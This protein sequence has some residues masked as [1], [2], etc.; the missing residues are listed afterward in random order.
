MNPFEAIVA[1]ESAAKTASV[2]P[3]DAI[4]ADEAAA[5]A[6][7]AQ[8][9]A[10]VDEF[11]EIK[12]PQTRPQF[13]IM[14]T[15]DIELERIDNPE[16][17]FLKGV[18]NAAI[19]AIDFMGDI[20]PDPVGAISKA[21][22]DT[23]SG[24]ATLPTDIAGRDDLSEK[25]NSFIPEII[26]EGSNAG[27]TN[28][29]ADVTRYGG[30][31]LGGGATVARQIGN[32]IKDPGTL[33]KI[34]KYATSL[35]GFG[36][37]DAAVMNPEKDLLIGDLLKSFNIDTGTAQD[38]DKSRAD[39]RVDAFQ[40][41][42]VAAPVVDAAMVPLKVAGTLAGKAYDGVKGYRSLSDANIE[43][44]I[45]EEI[46]SGVRASGADPAKVADDMD[47]TVAS[48]SDDAQLTSGQ[49]SNN[50]N[51]LQLDRGM[52][53]ANN[54]RGS[55]GVAVRPSTEMSARRQSQEQAVDKELAEVTNQKITREQRDVGEDAARAGIRKAQED[56]LAPLQQ[57]VDDASA[58]VASVEAKQ[59]VEIE[60][61]AQTAKN[62]PSASQSLGDT[63]EDAKGS[64]DSQ[65]NEAFDVDPEGIIKRK[66]QGIYDAWNGTKN[67]EGT[68]TAK[69]A[70][71][72]DSVE[73]IRSQLGKKTVEM[74]DGLQRGGD[75]VFNNIQSIRNG[76]TKAIKAATD[77][78]DGV[79][80]RKLGKLKENLNAEFERLA[81]QGGGNPIV[82]KVA[83]KASDAVEFFQS[84]YAPLLRDGAGK[85]L[86]D[87]IAK[88]ARNG[89]EVKAFFKTDAAGKAAADEATRLKGL[90][91]QSSDPAKGIKEVTDFVMA[92][93][94]HTTKQLN[95]KSIDNYIN[96]HS[97]LL[98]EFPEAKTVLEKL[99][100]NVNATA[101]DLVRAKKSFDD[102]SGALKLSEKE[103]NSSRAAQF[104]NDDPAE[105]AA[106]ALR[107]GNPEKDIVDMLDKA[108]R[109]GVPGAKEGVEQ[110]VSDAIYSMVTNTG[111]KSGDDLID[112]RASLGKVSKLLGK[113]KVRK[114]LRRVH[115]DEG[116]AT[117]DK[118]NKKLDLHA[119]QTS[120]AASDTAANVNAAQTVN[121][122]NVRIMLAAY[123]GITKGR[124]IHTISKYISDFIRG[125]TDARIAR[126]LLDVTLNP[127]KGA[128]FLRATTQKP[129]SAIGKRLEAND[130]IDARKKKFEAHIT[131]NYPEFFKDE[132]TE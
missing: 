125:D 82:T 48:V 61:K 84:T 50:V 40:E 96:T 107:G 93:M 117:L 21:T 54:V 3:F 129:T 31:G 80:K 73:F 27:A 60:Q 128:E 89:S 26:P 122:E 98:K 109:S 11:N 63:L 94:A 110:A 17:G 77:A 130:L 114:A 121:S 124:G 44:T 126:I 45:Q 131:N 75:E 2:N 81:K 112:F 35:L 72:A 12:A 118:V 7:A 83:Q 20:I 87:A 119:R 116:L 108:H 37:S 43:K 69:T 132:E 30:A 29:A 97:T 68:M 19:G 76:I 33:A 105:V 34:A 13:N 5:A 102:A 55:G 42:A 106:K 85:K 1:Q 24:L 79:A 36:A 47:A 115:G 90:I 123:F 25:I 104:L 65:K 74:L 38:P 127:K 100:R 66:S 91:D 64:L 23:V 57:S 52:A 120:V 46:Q 14:G 62:M 4:V 9:P 67:T 101:D 39:R 8:P 59:G 15:P 103:I 70:G 88:N 95:K 10:M 53:N 18:G 58:D 32:V 92:D 56:D 6:A 99:A 51:L 41:A 78:G 22:T 113:E 71:E 86:N 49:A 28:V 16:N 111:R